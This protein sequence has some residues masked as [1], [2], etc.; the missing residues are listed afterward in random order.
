MS[1]D[2]APSPIILFD[3][4]FF[5][6]MFLYLLNYDCLS[7]C[8]RFRMTIW[9]SYENS[10]MQLGSVAM[11]WK[12]EVHLLRINKWQREWNLF[13]FVPLWGLPSSGSRWTEHFL[14]QKNSQLLF[15]LTVLI[16]LMVALRPR[17]S[18]LC[19]VSW[20]FMF[21]HEQEKKQKNGRNSYQKQKRSR[22]YKSDSFLRDQTFLSPAGTN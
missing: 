17:L 10:E 12:S 22:R 15:L 18:S 20:W 5:S 2:K 9:Q 16:L 8:H 1:A 13:C 4:Y 6:S 7:S 14:P 19:P 3:Y 21:P 11:R